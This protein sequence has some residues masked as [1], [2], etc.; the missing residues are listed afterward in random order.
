MW[1]Y[2]RPGIMIPVSVPNGCHLCHLGFDCPAAWGDSNF[3]FVASLGESD[4]GKVRA[5][6]SHGA[7]HEVKPRCVSHRRLQALL[8]GAIQIHQQEVLC[9]FG[10]F[11]GDPE[12]LSPALH[13]LLGAK[14]GGLPVSV[15]LVF[16]HVSSTFPGCFKPN[17]CQKPAIFHETLVMDQ[18]VQL[19]GELILDQY[20]YFHKS[21][22]SSWAKRIIKLAP[23]S[24]QVPP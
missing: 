3:P 11:V 1:T 18:L 6:A 8:P 16:R 9:G 17:E 12:H 22:K 14:K 13:P 23:S 19:L 5:G 2:T 21:S 15:G 10:E 20:W 24:L 4:G 7:S